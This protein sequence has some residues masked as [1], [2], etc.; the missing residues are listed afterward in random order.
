VHVL[1]EDNPR[2]E[3]GDT[4]WTFNDGG[5]TAEIV[6]DPTNARRGSWVA[7]IANPTGFSA[8]TNVQQYP[9]EPGDRFVLQGF[10]KR[11]AGTDSV[12]LR[13]RWAEADGTFKDAKT[14]DPVTS[15][16]YSFA[17]V[18]DVAPAGAEIAEI[19]LHVAGS[20][21]AT[22]AYFDDIQAAIALRDGDI[23]ALQTTNGPAE[24]DA[25]QTT[26][27]SFTVLADRTADNVAPVGGAAGCGRDRRHGA[28]AAQSAVRGWRSRMGAVG[29]GR[30]HID[31]RGA[32]GKL[33]R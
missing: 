22:E 31:Q 13:L 33:L 27:K 26:G 25:E 20:D 15:S 23:D 5:G 10:A 4:G 12:Y 7:R 17:R 29:A 18:V 6:N 8:I 14:S 28:G 3:A 16:G 21:G 19:Q 11:T 32:V 2:F 30:D 1:K 9:V 24:A